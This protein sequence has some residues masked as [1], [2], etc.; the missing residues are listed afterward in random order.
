MEGN[1][2]LAYQNSISVGYTN[3]FLALWGAGGGGGGGGVRLDYPVIITSLPP[4]YSGIP[5]TKSEQV[6]LIGLHQSYHSP[7]SFNKVP[8][9]YHKI[10]WFTSKA[11]IL[12]HHSTKF[13]SIIIK[14]IGLHQSYHT[15]LSLNKVLLHYHKIKLTE[16][17]SASVVESLENQLLNK[18][19]NKFEKCL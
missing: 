9:H 4:G 11:T 14:L 19:S 6:K 2:G 13:H 18:C 3:Q 15:P 7:S 8:L 5:S 10:D 16:A 12:H 1:W 17:F